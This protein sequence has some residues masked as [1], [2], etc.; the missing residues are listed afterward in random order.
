M[1]KLILTR[2]PKA[3][4]ILIMLNFVFDPECKFEGRDNEMTSDFSELGR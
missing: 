4:E 3:T 1:S 2:A